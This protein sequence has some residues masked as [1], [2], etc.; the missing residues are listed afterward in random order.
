MTRP[1]PQIDPGMWYQVP[2]RRIALVLIA[3]AC[4][5]IVP[6]VASGPAGAA[7]P[8]DV[9]AVAAVPDGDGYIIVES[10]GV[11]WSYG[12]APDL[13]DLA[14]I[15][16]AQPIVGAAITPTGGG[17]WLVA[18]DGGVF[19]FGD[20]GFFGSTGGLALVEPV[21]GM[22]ATPTGGGYWLVASDGGVFAFGDAGFFG[23]TGAIALDLPVMSMTPTPSG[24]GY[25]LFA[26]DGGEFD[27]GDATFIGSNAARGVRFAAAAVT[28]G[29]DGHW[30]V[31]AKGQLQQ[32]GLAP[33]LGAPVAGPPTAEVPLDQADLAFETLGIFDEPVAIRSRPG[34]SS[35]VYVAER[36]GRIVR[37]D[38]GSA[39]R[40]T[41]L[42]MSNLTAT[43]NERGLLGFDFSPDGTKLY[44]DHT[45]L[46][47]SVEL[48][49]YDLTV[50]PPTRRLLLTIPQPFANHNGGDIH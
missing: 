15:G 50:S 40:T 36:S 43:D 4:L 3:A 13:G 34:D 5:A 24:R 45:N 6:P 39:V 19:A 20:A 27:F 42:D 7:T 35:G 12:E 8:I 23:S 18:S 41:L 28:P 21:V 14:G 1:R 46:A 29:G 11:V 32:S 2:M 37:Y 33:R 16:L 26:L 47:G 25:R 31:T 10:D 49:E 44:L 48:A 30:M 38:M 17:Y 22:A 9:V